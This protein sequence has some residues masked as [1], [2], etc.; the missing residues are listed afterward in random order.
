M[1]NELAST[2]IGDGSDFGD[3]IGFG[4]G[5]DE[6]YAKAL[7]HDG[8]LVMRAADRPDDVQEYD[9]AR[10]SA[11][12]D[13]TDMSLFRDVDGP[14]IDLGCG[15]GRMLIAARELGVPAL[16]VDLSDAAVHIARRSGA[17]VLLGSVF[18]AV[19]NEGG[20]DTAF[21]IDGN[22][23]IGGDPQ[24]LLERARDIVRK[25]GSIVVETNLDPDADR[26]FVATV[27]DADGGLSARFPWAAI[28][29]AGLLR[30]ARSAKL[31]LRG[32]WTDDG[33][34]FCRF[35]TPV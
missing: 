29:R 26:V 22:I 5:G 15:P 20:W 30:Y 9:V 10:W 12:A 17:D 34:T 16:G 19:P 11:A 13:A 24:R 28:G 21:L 18:D 8:R 6:P 23:G 7:E 31:T 14:I 4:R 33:R 27:T 2:G 3:D 32:S 25:G 1:S 35:A